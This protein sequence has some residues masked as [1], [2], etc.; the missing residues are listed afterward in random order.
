MQS[1]HT[2]HAHC[3]GSMLSRPD[4]APMRIAMVI[5]RGDEMG[6]AQL[7]V[8]TL[9]HGL[10]AAGHDIHVIAGTAGTWVDNL[11]EAGV[12]VQICQV[13][14]REIDPW[15]DLAAV[16]DLTARLVAI[17]PDLVCAH[18]SKAGLVARI[19][20]RRAGIRS[21]F[22]AHGW[23]FTDGVPQP[24]R[25]VFRS[26][27]LM[28]APLA[29]KI[30]CVSEHD[31]AIGRRAGIRADRLVTIH[32]GVPD[33]A[34]SLRANP[35]EGAPVRVVMV[36]RFAAQKDHATLLRAA[37]EVPDVQLD[38][39]GDGPTLPDVRQ[40]VDTLGMQDR[41]RFLGVR[42]DVAKLLAQSHIFVLASIFEGFPLSTLEAM[43]AGLPV[44]VS[45]VGGAGEAI[46]D[47]ES[48]FLV[49]RGDVE[50]LRDR[51]ELLATKPDRR[52]LMGATARRRFEE[53]FS[54]EAMIERTAALYH[55]VI[56]ATNQQ[57]RA[58]GS[59]VPIRPHPEHAP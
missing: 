42:G 55:D 56:H 50:T 36:A 3:A 58:R 57:R 6:G 33:V 43:R 49:P 24:K 9:V 44:I 47:H 25:A 11:A 39:V 51:L 40:L 48:G 34:D 46:I 13:M 32:N 54:A 2:H 41:V 8:S 12:P 29:S 15:R 38:L 59:L 30:I 18:S 7:H 16:R 17:A 20:A 28:M 19:A 5:T 1:A 45:N 52:V 4:A 23:A 26:V 37:A 10:I 21:I 35:R 22:T 31:R 14:G 27:E 53:R